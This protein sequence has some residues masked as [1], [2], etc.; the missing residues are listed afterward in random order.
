MRKYVF[1]LFALLL[2]VW[3]A[4]QSFSGSG[5]GTE[6]DPYLIFNPIQVDQVRNYCGT[7]GVYFKLMADV[8][9]A[10]YISDNNPTN[11]WQPIG[12]SSEPFKGI[13]DGNGKTIRNLWINRPSSDYVGFFAATSGATIKDLTLTYSGSCNGGSYTGLFIGNESGSTISNITITSDGNLVKGNDYTG[14]YIGRGTGSTICN[15]TITFNGV[16]NGS[17]YVGGF[18]GSAGSSNVSEVTLGEDVSVVGTNYVGGF[19]GYSSSSSFTSCSTQATGNSGADYLVKGTQ[20]IGGF[21]GSS[22]GG[23]FTLCTTTA[24]GNYPMAYGNSQVGGFVGYVS[25]VIISSCTVS[26]D[27]T[28]TDDF[29]GGFAGNVSSASFDSCNVESNIVSGGDYAGGFCGKDYGSH[30]NLSTHIGTVASE[31]DNIG[32][33]TGLSQ[34]SIMDK[35]SHHGD[36]TTNGSENCGGLIGNAVNTSI[37]NSLS[38]GNINAKDANYVGGIIGCFTNCDYKANFKTTVYKLEYSNLSDCKTELEKYKIGQSY[39]GGYIICAYYEDNGNRSNL[40]YRVVIVTIP[41]KIEISSQPYNTGNYCIYHAKVILMNA[42]DPEYYV[43]TQLYNFHILD[44]YYSGN[45]EGKS[46]LGGIIGKYESTEDSTICTITKN[47]ADGTIRGYSEVGGIVGY[48]SGKD[49][50]TSNVAMQ[51]HLSAVTGGIGR[52][53]GTASGAIIGKSGTSD[54]NTALTSCEVSLNGVKQNVVDNLQNGDVRGNST[55]RYAA[56][57]QGWDFDNDWEIQET[58]SYPYKPSQTAPPVIQSVLVSK[59]T[60]I[61][62][63]SVDGGTVYV[64]ADGQTYSS[65]VSSNQW[66]VTVPS[67]QSGASIYAYAKAEDLDYSYRVYGTV[68]YAGSGTEADPYQIYT[69][70]DL[71]NI[72]SYSYY[73]IMNDIDLSEYISATDSIN[74]WTPIGRSATT[75]RQLDGDGHTISGLWTGGIED[76]TGLFA[77]LD[78]ATIKNLTLSTAGGKKVSGGSYVGILVG[79]VA[80]CS[81]SAITLKGSAKG[82]GDYVGGLTGRLDGSTDGSIQN[83]CSNITA[84]VNVEG[85]NYTGGLVG[86]ID[87]VSI[88]HNRVSGTISGAQYV[89]GNFGTTNSDITYSSFDGTV[90]ATG[91]Y[92]GGI[93]GYGRSVTLSSS[94]GT[95][96]STNTDAIVGGIIGTNVNDSTAT[97][98][99]NCYSTATVKGGSYA[100]GVVGYNYLPVSN[101]Y[102]AGDVYANSRAAGVVGYN[103]GTLAT[104]SN[105]FAVNNRLVVTLASGYGIRVLGGYKNNAPTPES[106][107][108]ALHSM[109]VSVNDVSQKIYDDL[110][111][112]ISYTAGQMKTQAVY[113]RQG[114]DFDTVWGINEGEA[115]PYLKWETEAVGVSSITLSAIKDTLTVG[116]SITISATVLPATATNKGLV[117]TSSNQNVASVTETGVVKAIAQGSATITATAADNSGIAASLT[118][119]VKAAQKQE[120]DDKG[121]DKGKDTGDDTKTYANTLVGQ[122]VSTSSGAQVELPII[123]KNKAQI[124]DLQF[125]L[126][127]PGGVSIANDEDGYPLID[128]STDRSSTKRHNIDYRSHDTYTRILCTSSHG[129]KFN[130]NDGSVVIVTLDIADTLSAGDYTITMKNIVVSN[131]DSTYL[132][133][134]TTSKLSIVNYTLGD[135]N[136]DGLINVGDLSKLVSLV[137][138]E[139]TTIDNTFRAADTNQDGILN[140]GDYSKLVNMILDETEAVQSRSYI[141]ESAEA[142]YELASSVLE[143]EPLTINAGEEKAVAVRLSNNGWNYNA[144]QFDIYLPDGLSVDVE[145]ITTSVRTSGYSVASNGKRLIM[146]SANNTPIS[147]TSGDIVYLPVKADNNLIAGTYSIEFDNAIL[148]DT[149]CQPVRAKGF[150]SAIIIDN[151][152]GIN[153][154][155]ADNGLTVRAQKNGLVITTGATQNIRIFSASGALIKSLQMQAGES[156]SLYLVPGIYFVN[157]I[158]VNIK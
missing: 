29:L 4:S 44:N 102:S 121:D 91:N 37:S 22:N 42:R 41:V 126:Y 86:T 12:A 78:K 26:G 136:A 113:S 59:A 110:L 54:R 133:P 21:C 65:R 144:L 82:S 81:F 33:F 155:S 51:T 118:L 5:S 111:N 19:C 152:T 24:L 8:D 84:D 3:A 122:D 56:S 13:F 146:Y 50:I 107:N 156:K 123:M 104:T 150:S 71:A 36:I 76:Y 115:T 14:L 15:I 43:Y 46:Y 7:T 73:K 108:Y 79:K 157:N 87:N 55:L 68:S 61:S 60:T 53:Y 116:D 93:T 39:K 154:A 67:M 70:A 77:T 145:K 141:E 75:L 124:S 64:V 137:L 119:T 142:Q 149:D 127:L 99:I 45:I 89:G 58:E 69:A 128:V 57:Y 148:S 10:E 17:N 49:T 28:A 52:I 105:C 130:G 83:I 35:V 66:S 98:T 138:D 94:S 147:G 125:D 2:P 47:R 63:K 27:V 140:V 139:Y 151:P 132:V 112:G 135:V 143:A 134:Q 9:M 95:I 80:G 106:N 158:K 131:S 34:Q 97:G 16:I 32:G 129:Y 92:V 62:G 117:W 30:Y 103:D 74:G 25:S 1:F 96:S 6:S 90:S 38:I 48:N 72:N 85:A 11:G 120:E 18:C 23:S 114:W 109:A 101:C 40:L 88:S 153:T 100:A 31:W 20:Y